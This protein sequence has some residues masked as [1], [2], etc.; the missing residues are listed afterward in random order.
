MI[1]GRSPRLLIG[2][3]T[4]LSCAELPQMMVEMFIPHDGPLVGAHGPEKAVR[5]CRT[6][7]WTGLRKPV[8]PVEQTLALAGK[9][10]LAL[11][12]QTLFRWHIP[13][14]WLIS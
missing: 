7:F 3:L 2:K 6:L 14:D 1:L 5:V 12:D 9:I 8:D 4:S 13:A 10:S 11:H